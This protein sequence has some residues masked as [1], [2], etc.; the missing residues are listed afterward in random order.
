MTA[1]WSN[2]LQ[3]LPPP[4]GYSLE[5]WLQD[6]KLMNRSGQYFRLVDQTITECFR[7][8]K[9]NIAAVETGQKRVG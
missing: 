1:E 4:S 6:R 7:D 9:I 2:S 3:K 8:Q 5:I